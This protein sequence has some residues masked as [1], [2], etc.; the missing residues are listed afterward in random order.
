[1]EEVEVV[2]SER[3]LER[4]MI[5]QTARNSPSPMCRSQMKGA[6]AVLSATLSA[7]R[8]LNQSSLALVRYR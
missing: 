5:G 2:E 8:L 1:M 7:A 6:S 4:A 3:L